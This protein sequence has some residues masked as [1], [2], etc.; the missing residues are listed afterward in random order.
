MTSE[1]LPN[2]LTTEHLMAAATL[3]IIPLKGAR[4]QIRAAPAD[5]TVAI[6]CSPRFGLDRTLEACALAVRSGRRVVPH[7]A[8]RMVPGPRALTDFVRR[9]EDLGIT[10]LFVVGG[11]GETPVGPYHEAGHV[12]EDL[13]GRDHGLTRL[14]VGCY[15]EGHP[16]IDDER[17]WAALERKQKLATYMVSQ[18]CFDA[19]V[20]RKWLCRAQERGI[21]LPL[22]VGVAGPLK[23]TR[24]AELSLKVG[25]GQSL[26][27]LSKQRGMVGNVLLGRAYDPA[28]FVRAT[29]G[30]AGIEGLHVFSFNQVPQYMAWRDAHMPR[31]D[32]R[33]AAG[34]A[35]PR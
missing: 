17:L 1:P 22:R 13:R 3:E 5:A 29:A 20:V 32:A 14:G 15:P 21:G 10:E 34:E 18:M 9:I 19:T 11:D 35:G 28:P 30:A 27:Y 2:A 24:L 6:T 26:R 31:P 25:V 12:L 33:Q 7:L 8:A 16:R 23:I 4:E